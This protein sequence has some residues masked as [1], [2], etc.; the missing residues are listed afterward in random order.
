MSEIQIHIFIYSIKCFFY[1][2]R[3]IFN[4][5]VHFYNRAVATVDDIEA[6]SSV[7]FLLIAFSSQS[8]T[9]FQVRSYIL[10]F[11]FFTCVTDI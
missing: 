5:I 7:V 6:I 1:C 2:R 8:S 10:F 9:F 11:F 3:N 4:F